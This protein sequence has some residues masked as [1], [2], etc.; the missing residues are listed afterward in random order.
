MKLLFCEIENFGKFHRAKI[1]FND[2]ITTIKAD[3]GWGKS[4]LAAFLKCMFYGMKDGRTRSLDNER[5]K[6]YPWQGGAFGGAVV[7]SYQNKT[8][9]VERVFGKTPATDE[10]KIYDVKTGLPEYGLGD[11][12]DLGERLFGLDKDGYARTAFFEQGSVTDESVSGDIKAKLLSAFNATG[13]DEK[14]VEDALSRLD[15]AEKSLRKRRPYQ[16]KLDIVDE[17][18]LAVGDAKNKLVALKTEIQLAR[19]NLQKIDEE[20][21]TYNAKLAEFERAYGA[22][23]CRAQSKQNK[24]TERKN[25]KGC[26][27]AYLI[28]AVCI[29]ASIITFSFHIALSV[30]CL[31]IAAASAILGAKLYRKN[32]VRQAPAPME[33][34]T[35]FSQEQELEKNR[36]ALETARDGAIKEKAYAFSMLEEKEKTAQDLQSIVGEENELLFEKA[37]LEETLKALKLAKEYLLKAQ[38]S[39]ASK[40]LRPVAE[41]A[42]YYLTTVNSPLTIELSADGNAFVKDGGYL[43]EINYFS[44]GNRDIISFCIRLATLD[45]LYEKEKPF[46]LF[47]DPFV[48][49]DDT[50]EKAAKALLNELS[51]RYQTVYFT[52]KN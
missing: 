45:M 9:R 31:F 33:N 30:L 26:L 2:G 49:L 46:L 19:L 11:G 12:S 41:R 25:G 16:G 28:C 38:A 23:Q 36:Q 22:A 8:Y 47:D 29:L 6:Y 18:L 37:R 10:T 1:S 39:L 34:T 50:R 32:R 7:F 35:F 51:L 27:T 13:G 24:R 4:T 52:C 15:E 44:R 42:Q 17:K 48:N 5:K 14:G 20:L 21:S 43:R 3:N 40:Y